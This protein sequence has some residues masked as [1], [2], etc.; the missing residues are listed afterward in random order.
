M[1]KEQIEFLVL[2]ATNIQNVVSIA[3]EEASSHRLIHLWCMPVLL[4]TKPET[5]HMSEYAT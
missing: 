2:A 1:R 3:I 5:I 4:T